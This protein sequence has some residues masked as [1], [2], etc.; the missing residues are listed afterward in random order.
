MWVLQYGLLLLPVSQDCLSTPSRCLRTPTDQADRAILIT[1]PFAAEPPGRGFGVTRC[2][3]VPQ[4]WQRS[5]KPTA[6]Q[7]LDETGR[8]SNSPLLSCVFLWSPLLVP[9]VTKR[10]RQ[11]TG[12]RWPGARSFDNNALARIPLPDPIRSKP[13]PAPSCRFLART[14][15]EIQRDFS[16]LT[17]H[18]LPPTG[19]RRQ[20][21]GS[22]AQRSSPKY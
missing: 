18:V 21:Q 10:E 17:C 14:T 5:A 3:M 4:G 7:H 1:E 22:S 9:S 12:W 11:R 2:R 16:A 19:S 15:A 20:A 8:A 13:S 6:R